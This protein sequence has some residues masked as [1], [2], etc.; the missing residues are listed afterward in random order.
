MR[1]G[2][3]GSWLQIQNKFPFRNCYLYWDIEPYVSFT[4]FQKEKIKVRYLNKRFIHKNNEDF[5]FIGVIFT[6]WTKDQE[7]V[8]KAL[9]RVHRTL[10]FTQRKDYMEFIQKWHMNLLKMTKEKE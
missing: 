8:E 1:F 9:D 2:K 6:C 5:P 7:K 4:E 3:E 10:L